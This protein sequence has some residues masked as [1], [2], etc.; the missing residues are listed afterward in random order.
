MLWFDI[1]E[2]DVV[3]FYC[4]VYLVEWCCVGCVLNIGFCFEYCEN[5]FIGGGGFLKL[6]K[7][8]C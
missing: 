3:E 5:L 7:V 2:I 1:G 6:V 4:V 8:V